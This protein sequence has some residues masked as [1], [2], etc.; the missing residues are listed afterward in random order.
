MKQMNDRIL[1]EKMKEK[2]RKKEIGNR[3]KIHANQNFC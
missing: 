3:S 2:E 1:E